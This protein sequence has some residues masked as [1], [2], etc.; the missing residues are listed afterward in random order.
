MR[1][2]SLKKEALEEG[3]MQSKKRRWR[4]SAKEGHTLKR[5]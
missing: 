1:V 5:Q 2:K 4:E 3:N